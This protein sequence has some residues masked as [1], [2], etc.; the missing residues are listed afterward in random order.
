MFNAQN[1][2]QSGAAQGQVVAQPDGTLTFTH[3]HRYPDNLLRVTQTHRADGTLQSAHIVW[4]GF[5]GELLDLTAQFDAVG[6]WLKEEGYR[7]QGVKNAVTEFIQPLPHAA[8]IAPAAASTGANPLDPNPLDEMS[9][10]SSFGQTFGQTSA[11]P[12]A[13]QGTDPAQ[14]KKP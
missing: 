11:A 13:P 10:A 3:G 9:R 12:S 8:P 5:A 4:S 14:T 2:A 6:K 1:P 7:A